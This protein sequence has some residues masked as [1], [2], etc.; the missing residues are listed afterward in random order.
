MC[1]VE[2]CEPWAVC[3]EEWPAARKEHRCNECRRTIR[4]GEKYRKITGII[5]YPNSKWEN[6][7]ICEHCDAMSAWM[8]VMCGGWP[9][10]DLYGELVEHW[11]E[12]Y[13]SIPFGRLIACMRL[14]WHDGNDPVPE[15]MGAVAKS[16]LDAAV[17]A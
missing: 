13:A 2:D 8:T 6:H 15:G 5:S 14:K 17:A 11:R 16:M 12:G 3:R 7:R 1:A 4:S 9:L 10:D